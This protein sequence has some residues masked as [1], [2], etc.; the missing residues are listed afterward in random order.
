MRT[1]LDLANMK[2]ATYSDAAI[3]RTQFHLS[4]II[5]QQ[6]K[7]SR[8]ARE[9]GQTARSILERPHPL[10]NLNRVLQEHE[11]ALFDHLQ[12]VFDG[13]FTG[14]WILEYIGL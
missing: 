1:A 4:E 11:L 3:A 8:E 13:R 12:P 9:L 10:N 14:M 6:R 2:K 5:T 7:N